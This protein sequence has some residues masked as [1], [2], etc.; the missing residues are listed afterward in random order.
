MF[1]NCLDLAAFGPSKKWIT[2]SYNYTDG[3]CRLYGKDLPEQGFKKDL[4]KHTGTVFFNYH[5]IGKKCV[6]GSTGSAVEGLLGD[7]E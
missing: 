3:A 1:D 6:Q 4:K 7:A 2:F 5:C